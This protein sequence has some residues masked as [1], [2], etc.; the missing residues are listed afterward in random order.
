MKKNLLS[1]LSRTVVML[2]ACL[3]L[4][5]IVLPFGTLIFGGE[6]GIHYDSQ[7]NAC[8]DEDPDY[9]KYN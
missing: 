8:S 4:F 9:V 3:S 7:V 6:S 1:K 2:T 5:T